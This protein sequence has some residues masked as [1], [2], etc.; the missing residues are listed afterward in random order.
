MVPKLAQLLH[1]SG[2]ALVAFKCS[3]SYVVRQLRVKVLAMSK[4]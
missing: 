1:I 4:P 2:K 3:G